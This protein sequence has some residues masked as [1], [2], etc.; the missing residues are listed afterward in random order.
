M[1][2]SLSSCWVLFS[3]SYSLPLLFFLHSSP[4]LYFHLTAPSLPYLLPLCPT[5]FLFALPSSSLP[6]LLPLYPTSSLFALPSPSL[7]YLL[8]LCPT[9]SLSVS[10]HIFTISSQLLIHERPMITYNPT[11]HNSIYLTVETMQRAN[12]NHNV[13][14][15]A[16]LRTCIFTLFLSNLSKQVLETRLNNQ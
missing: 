1:A 12:S 3:S 10:F 11:S 9:F 7:P 14:R 4:P 5:F 2:L 15:Y 8:P 13:F 16:I 6:Y